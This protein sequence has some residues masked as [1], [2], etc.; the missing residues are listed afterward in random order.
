MRI[1]SSITAITWVPFDALDAMPNLPLGLALAHHDEPPPELLGDLEELR[2]ADRFREANELRAWIEVVHGEIVRFGHEGRG[3]AASAFDVP[4]QQVAFPALEFPIIRPAPEAHADH[5]RF[6]QTVGGRIGLPV[7]RPVA[8][9]PYFHVGSATGWTTLELVL[10]VDGTAE[11]RLVDASPLPR[12]SVYGADG[13]LVAEHGS[14]QYAALHGDSLDESPWG[15]L[16]PL[17]AELDA[18]ALRSRARLSRRRLQAGE[19][20]VEQGERGCDMFLLVDGVLDVEV[21]RQTVAQVGAGALLGELA[22]LGDGRRTATLRAA[23][24]S[25]VAL[26]TAASISGSKL[27]ELAAASRLE[28]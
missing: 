8:G 16:D 25:R 9:K 13:Q 27:P 2:A 23:R 11:A 3:L 28:P 12:H 10:R 22:V 7:P 21:D 26:L 14:S 4:A 20:L 5:V 6:T 19:T 15:D 17:D 18:V 1:E 24:P